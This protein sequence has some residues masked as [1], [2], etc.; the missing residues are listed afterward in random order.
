MGTGKRG[1][2]ELLHR[3]CEELP[4]PTAE[5]GLEREKGDVQKHFDMLKRTLGI[6]EDLLLSS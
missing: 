4:L 5:L 1:Q 2:K 3:S 6:L